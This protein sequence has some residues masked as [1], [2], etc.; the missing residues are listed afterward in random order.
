MKYL[1][2]LAVLVVIYMVF[3]KA[4]PVNSVKEAMD[5]TE[6]NSLS[7]GAKPGPTATAATM[8]PGAPTPAAQKNTTGLRAPITRTH[9][10]LDA[11][12]ARNGTGEF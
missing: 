6:M 3:L 7:T 5:Q 4:S 2:L 9:A 8:T 10:A 12:K 11:V 1:A